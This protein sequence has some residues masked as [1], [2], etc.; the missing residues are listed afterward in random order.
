MD[1][2]Q[3]ELARPGNTTAKMAGVCRAAPRPDAARAALAAR[4]DRFGRDEEGSAIVLTLFI[5]MFMMVMAG[6]GIDTMRQEMERTRL[7]ATLDAAVLAGAGMPMGTDATQIK[8][9]VEDYFTKAE[10]ANYLHQIDTQNDILTSLN[11]TRVYAEASKTID[12]YLMQISGVDTLSASGAAAAEVRT[13]K[14]EI[15]LILDTSGSMYGTKIAN[16]KTAAKSFVSTIL[17]GSEPGNTAISLIPFAWNVTPGTGIY[18]ALTV[19]ETHDYSTC[20]RFDAADYNATGIDPAV[21][22]DQQ[23]FTAIYGGFDNPVAGWRSCF[24]ED[25]A[26]ILPFSMSETA[27]H[28]RIDQLNADGN[29]SAHIGLKWGAAMLDPKFASVFASLQATGTVDAALSNLPAAY[30]E[31]EAMKIIVLMADGKN[32]TSYY[33]NQN[34]AYRGPD[35]DLFLMKYQQMQFKYAYKKKKK[36]GVQYSYDEGKCSNSTWTCIYEATGEE[37]SAYYLKSG[38]N[39]FSIEENQWISQSDYDAIKTSEGFISETQ[40]SWEQAWGLM[41]P[42]FF[43]ET[44]GNWGPWN[45]YVGSEYVNGSA[46][47]SRMQAIC[48][49]SKAQNVI[50][51]TIGY[52]ISSGGNAETQ[53]Q[54]CASSANHYYPTNGSNISAAF[55]SIASNVQN[56]RLT[57]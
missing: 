10:M 41:S 38:S 28:A 17:N 57:Q 25:R 14:L 33:F 3:S 56:L 11:A 9:V 4:I 53:L 8:A 35:S 7:Q 23:I 26:E 45:D 46:K 24:P 31:P 13:P 42:R 43:G 55:N 6:L 19:N 30:D 54:N 22:Y 52:G 37:V 15:S 51:Y 5:F 2:T 29:T 32:T 20:L 39:Y 16:L 44:T 27:L 40:L 48:G 36:G 50:I 12:T 49:A 47:D 1:A 34:S 21:S 18:N